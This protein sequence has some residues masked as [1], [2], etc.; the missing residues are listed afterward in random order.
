MTEIFKQSLLHFK[1]LCMTYVARSW[2]SVITMTA[3]SDN[4]VAEKKKPFLILYIYTHKSLI[5]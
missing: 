2:Y 5:L 1:E 3:F 4:F